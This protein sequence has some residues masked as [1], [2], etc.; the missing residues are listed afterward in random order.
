MDVD[1]GFTMKKYLLLC[2]VLSCGL[3][4]TNIAFVDV[5]VGALGIGVK[6]SISLDI[7]IKDKVAIQKNEKEIDVYN[8]LRKSSK[9]EVYGSPENFKY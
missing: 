9:I 3:N 1:K 7:G 8:Y 6:T 4:A 5:S 2:V